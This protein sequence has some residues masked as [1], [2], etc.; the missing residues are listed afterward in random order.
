MHSVSV[1]SL[2]ATHAATA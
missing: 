1:M 2:S